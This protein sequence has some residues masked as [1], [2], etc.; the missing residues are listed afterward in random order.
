MEPSFKLEN[1][2]LPKTALPSGG[3]GGKRFTKLKKFIA[4]PIPLNWITGAAGVRGKTL[5]VALALQYLAG[6]NRS[7][8]VVLSHATLQL[9]GV[10]RQAGNRALF[11]LE[12]IELISV[13]R[14][15]GRSPVVT[16]LDVVD[17]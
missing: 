2:A 15:V 16:I 13:N 3:G 8:T 5:H 12:E 1:L 10:S 11:Q 6:L 17:P 9:F 14:H 4:G 7:R